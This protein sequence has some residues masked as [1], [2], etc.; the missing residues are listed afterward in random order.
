MAPAEPAPAAPAA[1]R[2][3]GPPR[4]PSSTCR[5]PARPA[6]CSRCRCPPQR[7]ERATGA[8]LNSVLG[9]GYSSR[10][11]QEIRIKRGLSYGVGSAPRRAPRGGA[12][13][14]RGPDQERVGG[15]GRRPGAIG[16]RPADDRSRSAPTSSPRARL[17]LIGGFSR[18]VETTAGLGRPPSARWSSRTGRRPSW[19]NASTRSEPSPPP[20]SSAMPPRT[21]APRSGDLAVAGEASAFGAALKAAQPGLVTVG[22]DALDLERGDGLTALSFAAHGARSSP[23]PRSPGQ[24]KPFVP[25]RR[26]LGQ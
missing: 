12:V 14:R 26:L 17:T 13:P 22:Q 5:S 16:D 2:R 1:R 25:G 8:V 18:S 6:W 11:N 20:T 15:R 24:G 19:S 9:G 4:R 3:G 23:C 7:H 21:S 10:L